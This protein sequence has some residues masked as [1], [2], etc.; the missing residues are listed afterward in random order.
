MGMIQKRAVQLIPGDVIVGMAAAKTTR[1]AVLHVAPTEGCVMRVLLARIGECRGGD[2]ERMIEITYGFE[3]KMQVESA[4]PDLTPAQLH[5]EELAKYATEYLSLIET[6]ARSGA[7]LN[8]RDCK[9][10]RDLLETIKPPEP[11][12]L[13]EALEII[14][15]FAS[16]PPAPRPVSENAVAL[17][18]KAIDLLDRAR[19]AKVLP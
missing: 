8:E 6:G 17:R 11:P 19:A 16:P 2:S 4:S 10:L 13:A 7:C 15:A 9:K 1:N 14:I 3:E 12:T 18:K 5:A